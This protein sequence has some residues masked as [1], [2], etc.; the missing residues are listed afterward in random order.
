MCKGPVLETAKISVDKVH[1]AWGRA[2]Q[3]GK[4]KG[5]VSRTVPS[6][7][8]GSGRV[9]LL[10]AVWSLNWSGARDRYRSTAGTQARSSIFRCEELAMEME[11]RGGFERFSVVKI[12]KV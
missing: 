12:H 3:A 10:A 4:R 5:A 9:G 11:R 7:G 8:V 6:S 1:G 2:V